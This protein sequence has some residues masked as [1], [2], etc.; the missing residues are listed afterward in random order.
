MLDMQVNGAGG[1]DLTEEPESVWRVGSVL[2]RF[3]TTAFLPTLVSPSWAI[4]ERAQAALAGG[5]PAGYVGA[6]PLGWH[7]EGPF[8]NPARA[9]AHDPASLQ[10]PDVGA[11]RDWSPASGIR[12]VTLAPELWGALDVV[13][14][15]VDHGVVVS[16]GHSAATFDEAV[17]GFDA[18]IRAATHLFNAMAPLDHREPGIVG[19]ALTD[20]RV[21]IGLIPDGLHVHPAI[22]ALVRR[23][24]GGDRLA[25]V[26][27]AIAALGMPPGTHRLA[28]RLVDC[29]ETSARL[30]N[31][32]LAGSVLGLD[33]AVRNLATFAGID[34]ADA[35]RAVTDVPA[36]LLGLAP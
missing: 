24:V 23:A 20:P 2:A 15:L 22:V 28:G 33:Q 30:P 14:V 10:P 18:G 27:D 8:L 31:G 29:D 34:A 3:G 12:M 19:A 17:A 6:D 21:A 25:I 11:V 35:M 36:R 7:V 1:F 13:R 9:G 16:A 4:V 32:V 26:T 5:P